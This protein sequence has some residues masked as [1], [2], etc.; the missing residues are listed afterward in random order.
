MTGEAICMIENAGLVFNYE[1]I[2]H[3]VSDG[4]LDMFAKFVGMAI[5]TEVGMIRVDGNFIA[6]KKMLPLL[7]PTIDSGELLIIDI[8]VHFGFRECL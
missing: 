4:T 8:I 7:K 5:V 6:K 3:E 1:V 2:L